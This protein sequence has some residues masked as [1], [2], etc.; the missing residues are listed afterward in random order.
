MEHIDIGNGKCSCGFESKAKDTEKGIAMH[1][2]QVERKAKKVEAKP[3]KKAH[4]N[5]GNGICGCGADFS[6]K[7]NP[8]K[9]LM[10]HLSQLKKGKKLTDLTAEER[11]ERY[12]KRGGD[13]EYK[14]DFSDRYDRSRFVG[15]VVNDDPGRI[16]RMLNKGWDF[17]QETTEAPT[18]SDN[19]DIGTNVS[20][21]VDG[22]GKRG[23]LMVMRKEWYEEDKKVKQ[24]KLDKVDA[25]IKRGNVPGAD[26]KTSYIPDD[27]PMQPD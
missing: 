9:A 5:L 19:M 15:R 8:D 21:P 4:K 23:Y 16:E 13:S 25:D 24:D 17:V 20:R 3:A 2:R 6:D 18:G 14:L 27:A 12:K 1:L 10:G 7:K 26:M 22:K 11:R